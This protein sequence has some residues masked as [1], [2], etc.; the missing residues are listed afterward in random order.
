MPRAARSPS[1][2]RKRSSAKR[3]ASR[4]NLP[5]VRYAVIGLGH[6]AQTAVLPGMAQAKGSQ[7]AALVSDDPVKLK[8]LG[9]RYQ[10]PITIGYE[11]LEGLL[12]SGEIDAVY[13]ALPN[14]LHYQFT[15]RA[16]CLGIHVLVEKPMAVTAQQCLV[17]IET[18][19]ISQARLMVA[20]RLHFERANLHAVALAQE[21]KIGELRFFNSIFSMQVAKGDIRTHPVA[22]GGGPLYDLGVYCI[23][24]ARGLFQSEPSEVSAFAV[25]SDDERFAKTDEMVTAIMR[26]PGERLASFTASF[27]AANTAAYDLVGTLGSVRLD[28]AYEYAEELCQRITIKGRTTT[29]TQ[30]VGDQFAAEIDYFSRCIRTGEEPEP[31]GVEGFADVRVVEAIIESVCSGRPV[32]IPHLK[33]PLQRPEPR[34]AI[35]YPAGTQPEPVHAPQPHQDP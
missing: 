34:L 25:R 14:E 22:S 28:P 23:N 4:T 21:R 32:A 24:A 27:G 31:S 3:P 2:T 7:I 19:T 10:V 26:F 33:M 29:R 18:A 30:P 16:L 8:V 17:M 13:I 20:Y 15:M 6:I 12:A 5:P 11:D 9:R 1:P 35:R